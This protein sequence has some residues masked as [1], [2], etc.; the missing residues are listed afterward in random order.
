MNNAG[1]RQRRGI[2]QSGAFRSETTDYIGLGDLVSDR[3]LSMSYLRIL[4]L[5]YIRLLCGSNKESL[6]KI[7]I[8]RYLL[9]E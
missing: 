5:I 6:V 9:S 8:Y 1:D 3:V 2:S 4:V 7:S